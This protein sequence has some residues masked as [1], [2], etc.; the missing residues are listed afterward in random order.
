MCEPFGEQI[1]FVSPLG[2]SFVC[3]HFGGEFMCVRETP[4]GRSFV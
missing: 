4:L 3:E 1:L 2:R